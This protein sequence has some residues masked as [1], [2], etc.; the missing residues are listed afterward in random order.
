MTKDNIAR[1]LN[2][3][4]GLKGGGGTEMLKGVQMAITEPIDKE[5]LRVVIM[6]TDGFIGNEAQ[7]LEE[8]GKG[9]GNQ[10]RFWCRR[11]PQSRLR[12]RPG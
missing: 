10:I 12:R 9:C 2:F 11:W 4:Q 8:I 5:R 1:A 6:F 3:T 7:I